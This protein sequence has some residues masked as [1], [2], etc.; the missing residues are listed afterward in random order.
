VE[1][2]QAEHCQEDHDTINSIEVDFG[3]DDP[4]LPT[5]DE[6]DGSV[7]GSNSNVEA[8][9]A[10]GRSEEH[11]LDVLIHEVVPGWWLVDR[12]LEGLV[13]EVTTDELDAEDHVDGDGE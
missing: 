1:E 10:E 2:V 9:G 13:G 8:E 12:T 4:A 3:G 6:F 11:R 5:V 7:Y